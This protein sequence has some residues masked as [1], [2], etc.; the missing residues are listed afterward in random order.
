MDQHEERAAQGREKIQRLNAFAP[1]GRQRW[2]RLQKVGDVGTKGGGDLFQ[3]AG[4]QGL[5]E[6][7]IQAQQRDRRVAAAAPK[8]RSQRNFLFQ[9]K[10]H[11]IRNFASAQ[12]GGGWLAYAP[13]GEQRWHAKFVEQRAGT[14]AG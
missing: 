4:A 5:A 13:L 10:A 2:P 12:K 6:Q 8:A 3:L 7:F 9:M 11:A 1:P 14:R